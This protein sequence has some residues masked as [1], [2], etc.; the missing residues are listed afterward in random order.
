M[1]IFHC[2]VTV[3]QRVCGLKS[4]GIPSHESMPKPWALA[5]DASHPLWNSWCSPSPRPRPAPE[6]RKNAAE[7]VESLWKTMENV[8]VSR[9]DHQKSTGNHWFGRSAEKLLN[10]RSTQ[11]AFIS[12]S[13]PDGS[14]VGLMKNLSGCDNMSTF[15]QPSTHRHKPS[16][17]WFVL[18]PSSVGMFFF[19]GILSSKPPGISN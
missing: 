2:Y 7:N 16:C 13:M 4:W 1:V 14:K 15:V 11:R 18:R 6:L 19:S 10:S 3:H 5:A 8:T 12:R 9:G 17:R